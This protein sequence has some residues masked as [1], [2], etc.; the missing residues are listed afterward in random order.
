MD[1]SEDDFE[2]PQTLACACCGGDFG[3]D[4]R[5]YWCTGEV[6]CLQGCPC[7]AG[8]PPVELVGWE[9]DGKSVKLTLNHEPPPSSDH[10]FRVDLP[11]A[12]T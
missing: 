3:D 10:E 6:E 9:R 1:L 2:T 4:P 12:D 8:L 5:C 7:V 11:A